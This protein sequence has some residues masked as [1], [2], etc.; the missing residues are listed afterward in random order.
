MIFLVLIGIKLSRKL[1]NI[2]A[3]KG[4]IFISSQKLKISTNL[5][6]ILLLLA[7]RLRLSSPVS[8]KINKKHSKITKIKMKK[9][10]ALSMTWSPETLTG[11][12]ARK[13]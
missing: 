10:K 12:S 4:K 2:L 6:H 9:I 11:T 13:D 7:N 1:R 5:K 3:K 8:A